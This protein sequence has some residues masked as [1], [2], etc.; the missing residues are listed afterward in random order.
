M[1]KERFAPT[2]FY[3]TSGALS[4]AGDDSTSLGWQ[5]DLEVA[6]VCFKRHCELKS[7]GVFGGDEPE[8]GEI[9]SSNR[10]LTW[11]A[12]VM[13]CG[14]DERHSMGYLRRDGHRIEA[15]TSQS[16][17]RPGSERTWSPPRAR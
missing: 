9:T 6:L 14:A 12:G 7:R 8:G 1:K 10:K 15:Q 2:V 16:S 13:T 17:P 11:I 4:T 3:S 5:K